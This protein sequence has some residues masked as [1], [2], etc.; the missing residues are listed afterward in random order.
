MRN[1]FRQ[2]GFFLNPFRFAGTVQSGDLNFGGEASATIAGASIVSA[3]ASSDGSGELV[4]GSDQA[5]SGAFSSISEGGLTVEGAAVASMTF[6]AIGTSDASVVAAAEALLCDAADFDGTNDSMTR[7]SSMTGQADSKTGILSM[8]FKVD[9][10]SGSGVS[11]DDVILVHDATTNVFGVSINHGTDILTISGADGTGINRLVMQ[12]NS[13]LATTGFYH[14]LASWDLAAATGQLYINDV[15]DLAAGGTYTDAV[16]RWA[17]ATTYKVSIGL[18]G[19]FLYDGGLAEVYIA[20]GQYIDLSVE[21]NR[22]K[23]ITA[24]GK[25]VNLG[26]TGSIPTGTNPL[27][28]LHL[29][30][31][32][33]A[34]NFAINRTSAGNYTVSG[35]LTTYASSPSD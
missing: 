4:V 1:R 20:P 21:E 19:G 8:W 31:G 3:D 9:D 27:V 30:D 29:E 14:V 35:A 24:D 16:L 18:S 12:T 6:S 25:P 15:S 5:A 34:S 23:F 10:L 26:A 28:Y 11:N 17:S 32:E 33:T 7:S 2:R 22:R 13:S